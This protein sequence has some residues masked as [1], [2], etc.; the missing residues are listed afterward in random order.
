MI[1]VLALLGALFVAALVVSFRATSVIT[2]RGGPRKPLMSA[3]ERAL[4]T[5]HSAALTRLAEG[6]SYFSQV[7]SAAL[8]ARGEG[9]RAE[10]GARA[11]AVEIRHRVT[12]PLDR[13]RVIAS[14]G[15]MLGLLGALLAFLEP[16]PESMPIALLEEGALQFH[17]MTRAAISMA[18]GLAV[19]AYARQAYAALRVDVEAVTKTLSELC[20][21][22][23]FDA[24]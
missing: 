13:L 3:L 2:G 23:A 21:L 6:E 24:R 20:D 7:V 18:A 9:G 14:L 16:V 8:E 5:D 17:R 19:H 11:A 12:I 10:L 15:S 4:V 1:V 22:F